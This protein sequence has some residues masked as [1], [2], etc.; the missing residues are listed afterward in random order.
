MY[1]QFDSRLNMPAILFD[2]DRLV[3]GKNEYDYNDLEDI[4]I[5][6]APFLSTYGIIELT[7]KEGK[8]VPI[9]FVKGDLH[10]IR[11]AVQEL[12]HLLKV[13]GADEVSEEPKAAEQGAEEKTAVQTAESG[14]GPASIDPYEEMK[15]LKELLDLEIVTQEEFDR[16]KKQ[17]LGL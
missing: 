15:K 17:L 6:K 14:A 3:A 2:D 7:T 5:T 11:T 16:K 8:T 12:S 1:Y 13:R 10:R 9:P 4:K